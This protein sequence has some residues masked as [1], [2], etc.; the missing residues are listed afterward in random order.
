[1]GF[2][3]NMEHRFC[4][5]PYCI[6]A[7]SDAA[8]HL[9]VCLSVPFSVSIPFARWR[10]WYACRVSDTPGNLL[11]LFFLLE[12][13]KISCKFFGWVCVFRVIMTRS[14]CMKV[15]W[16]CGRHRM[17]ACYRTFLHL[18]WNSPFQRPQI[19]RNFHQNVSWKS[20]GN[21]TFWSVRHPA[22]LVV[23]NSFDG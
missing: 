20:T 6:G 18:S 4:P 21:H 23:I 3:S 5:P 1:M 17:G 19:L 16:R 14:S 7:L 11:E 8:I 15:G 22:Y 2:S 13:C 12:I 9:S 10:W